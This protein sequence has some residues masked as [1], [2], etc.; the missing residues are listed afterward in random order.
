MDFSMRDTSMTFALGD[1]TQ[2]E[3][4]PRLDQN[5]RRQQFDLLRSSKVQDNWR[6]RRFQIYMMLNKYATRL[7]ATGIWEIGTMP[8]RRIFR[9]NPRHGTHVLVPSSFILTLLSSSRA[10]EANGDF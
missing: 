3:Y 10:I 1:L 9:W 6:T 4:A 8:L 2:P 7:R 5:H